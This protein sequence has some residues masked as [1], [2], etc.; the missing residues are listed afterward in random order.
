[1]PETCVHLTLRDA[2]GCKILYT[3]DYS[4]PA[5]V[6]ATESNEAPQST[7]VYERPIPLRSLRGGESLIRAVCVSLDGKTVGQSVARAFHVTHELTPDPDPTPTPEETKPR[8]STPARV[9][10]SH[11]PSYTDTQ[12][13]PPPASKPKVKSTAYPPGPP[14]SACVSPRS[15][16]L[17]ADRDAAVPAELSIVN[18]GR[19]PSVSPAN[20]GGVTPNRPDAVSPTTLPLRG[21]RMSEGPPSMHQRERSPIRRMSEGPPAPPHAVR[22]RSPVRKMSEAPGANDRA[23]QPTRE[24]SPVRRMSERPGAAAQRERSPVKQGGAGAGGGGGAVPTGLASV[25]SPRSSAAATDLSGLVVPPPSWLTAKLSG[26]NSGQE[27]QQTSPLPSPGPQELAGPHAAA[28]SAMRTQSTPAPSTSWGGG[29]SRPPQAQR[30]EEDVVAVPEGGVTSLDY[31]ASIMDSGTETSASPPASGR[32]TNNSG[33]RGSFG[34][35]ERPANPA[36]QRKVDATPATTTRRETRLSPEHPRRGVPARHTVGEVRHEERRREDTAV[37]SASAGHDD[38]FVGRGG[39]GGGSDSSARLTFLKSSSRDDAA[40]NDDTEGNDV[41][42]HVCDRCGRSWMLIERMMK[43]KE[44]CSGPSRPSKSRSPSRKVTFN[45]TGSRSRS[46]TGQGVRNSSF[47]DCNSGLNGSFYS[48]SSVGSASCYSAPS[49]DNRREREHNAV[50]PTTGH[51]TS[52]GTSSSQSNA[53]GGG[54]APSM[55]NMAAKPKFASPPASTHSSVAHS[56][57]STAYSYGAGDRSQTGTHRSDSRPYRKPNIKSPSR[58][59]LAIP[60]GMQNCP[61]CSRAM[62]EAA[63]DL[64]VKKCAEEPS[65]KKKIKVEEENR[66]R[67]REGTS[68]NGSYTVPRASVE[69]AAVPSRFSTSPNDKR[70]DVLPKSPT[71]LKMHSEPQTFGRTSTLAARAQLP[72]A[73]NTSFTPAAVRSHTDGSVPRDSHSEA[74]STAS[75]QRP[76]R[77]SPLL[78]DRRNA[79]KKARAQAVSS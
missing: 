33:R 54:P 51:N 8:R 2:T 52:F 27:S 48:R 57:L 29:F 4:T 46:S 55:N 19:S 66:R 42:Q 72:H 49:Y 36:L 50:P 44:Y 35:D 69:A 32:S 16:P 38:V 22:E 7:L 56:R 77:P 13:V 59:P 17:G 37:R 78:Q 12:N 9:S 5:A 3:T 26:G 62:K 58:Q 40:S 21:A 25:R 31:L 64:H 71:P 39:G 74:G 1:M 10:S 11:P 20:K 23:P 15:P 70:F 60:K 34:N 63:L 43:H 18:V 14:R 61:Y 47:S 67:M 53:S 75:S 76:I 45:N 24:R 28:S 6:A 30:G 73:Q 41:P 65:N 79:W 68:G